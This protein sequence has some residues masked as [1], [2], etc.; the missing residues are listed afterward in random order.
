MKLKVNLIKECDGGFTQPSSI[1]GIRQD[2]MI[3]KKKKVQE[4]KLDRNSKDAGIQFRDYVE[5][6][7]DDINDYIDV[8]EW[9]NI[10]Y[11]LRIEI[12]KFQT[13]FNKILNK[14]DSEPRRIPLYKI[15]TM[16]SG[17]E[18]NKLIKLLD[19]ANKLLDDNK[20]LENYRKV[21]KNA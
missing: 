3:P 8:A 20:V 7:Q 21:I 15:W 11:K 2:L 10:P 12:T 16:L 17:D 5:Q 9:I 1:S 18:Q 13:E 6:T 14:Y 19:N 4:Y